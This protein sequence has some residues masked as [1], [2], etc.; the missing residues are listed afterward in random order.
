MTRFNQYVACAALLVCTVPTASFA[1]G[2]SA[3]SAS[4]ATSASVGSSSTSIQ[5]SS[6]SSTPDAPVAAGDYRIVEVVALAERPGT[7][8]VM[9]QALADPGA[10]GAF[11]LVL[12]EAALAG[13][14]L[15]QGHV[16]TAR[17]RPYGLE[18]ANGATQQPF[19]LVLDDDW[20]RELQTRA[21]A[22]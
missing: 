8:R 5:K 17:Q 6:A 16:V 20:Y 11:G 18:F 21:I 7:V 1:A 19:Y 2:S 9:L 10:E 12:P 3:S 14:G 15:A 22:G 4:S 13:G